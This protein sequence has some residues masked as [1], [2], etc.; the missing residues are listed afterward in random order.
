VL[1][2]ALKLSVAAPM[3]LMLLLPPVL[4]GSARHD[5]INVNSH[6]LLMVEQLGSTSPAEGASL[7]AISGDDAGVHVLDCSCSWPFG[8]SASKRSIIEPP[9]CACCRKSRCKTC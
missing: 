5:L 7:T 2:P 4:R 6:V 1:P 8:R 9:A 3:L